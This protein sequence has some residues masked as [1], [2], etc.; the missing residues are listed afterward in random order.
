MR[1]GCHLPAEYLCAEETGRTKKK[2]GNDGH[3]YIS[4]LNVF[5]PVRASKEHLF[6]ELRSFC[7]YYIVV[8][9][10]ISRNFL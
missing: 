6:S 4:R 10:A 2:S 8:R 5:G 9:G 7:I 1:G 3:I